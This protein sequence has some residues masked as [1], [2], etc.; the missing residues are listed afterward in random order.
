MIKLLDVLKKKTHL[1][2]FIVATIA[3]LFTYPYI[4]SLGLIEIWFL[5]ITPLNLVLYIIFSVLFGLVLSMQIYVMRQPKTCS[6]SGRVGSA[7]SGAVGSFIAFIT[8]ACPACFSFISLFLPFGAIAFIA[9]Y[10]TILLVLSLF[11]MVLALY[12]LGSFK[13]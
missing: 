5:L 11:V 1:S 2:I 7:G 12:L 13:R 9:T 10:N 8:V 4:Q 3:M 6:I